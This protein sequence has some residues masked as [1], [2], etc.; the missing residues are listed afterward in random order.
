MRNGLHKLFWVA[1]LSLATAALG[2]QIRGDYVETLSAD[3]YT[4]QCFANGEANL[5]GDEALLEWA[6]KS[7]S[8][9]GV[10]LGGLTVAAAVQYPATLGVPYANPYPRQPVLIVDNQAGKPQRTALVTF[11]H[12]IGC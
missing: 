9:E 10:P 11:T 12:Q 3:V 1:F 6:V 7:G 2:Q 8:R 4:G 5:V